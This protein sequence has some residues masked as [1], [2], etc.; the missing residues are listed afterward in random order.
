MIVWKHIQGFQ[1]V[2]VKDHAIALRKGSAYGESSP[3]GDG[4]EN[5]G[6]VERWEMKE[7]EIGDRYQRYPARI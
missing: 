2:Q 4:K 3:Q 7:R 5:P 6:H 1:G